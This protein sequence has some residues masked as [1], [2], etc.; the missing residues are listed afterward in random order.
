M[1]TGGTIRGPVIEASRA[2]LVLDVGLRG[3]LPK[4][5]I[6]AGRAGNLKS[7]VGQELECKVVEVDRRRNNVVLSRRELLV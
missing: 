1:Q 6:G 2:G 7:Y 5:K 3:F 4:S